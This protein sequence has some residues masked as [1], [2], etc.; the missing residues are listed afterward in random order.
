MCL[1]NTE[2]DGVSLGAV[3]KALEN[4]AATT[5]S[6]NLVSD[7]GDSFP[8]D[9]SK[10]SIS[11]LLRSE[12]ADKAEHPSA[13]EVERVEEAEIAD[14]PGMVH[15]GPE[16]RNRM[17]LKLTSH[18]FRCFRMFCSCCYAHWTENQGHTQTIRERTT[19]N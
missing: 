3:I 2:C 8:A 5:C 18:R 4:M 14:I 10:F 19:Q 6:I 12:H 15:N 1:S 9:A 13:E 11:K 7:D 16:C 17:L